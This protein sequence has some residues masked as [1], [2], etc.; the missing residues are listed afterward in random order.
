LIL[1][2]AFRNPFWR[3]QDTNTKALVVEWRDA[4]DKNPGRLWVIRS[5]AE[6]EVQAGDIGPEP[7]GLLIGALRLSPGMA[8]AHHSLAL[9]YEKRRDYSR[10]FSGYSSE[11]LYSPNAEAYNGAGIALKE[12]GRFSEG[13]AMYR[14]AIAANTLRPEYAYNLGQLEMLDGRPDDAYAFFNKAIA[15]DPVNVPRAYLEQ[16]MILGA[17]KMYPQAVEKLRA[18]MKLAPRDARARL[19]LAAAYNGAGMYEE[20]ERELSIALTASPDDADAL[21]LMARVRAAQGDHSPAQP[22]KSGVR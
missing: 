7:E 4:V 15:L 10:A 3:D 22:N 14:A 5:L 21:R 12:L 2:T 9:L 18:Y 1:L 11:I 16:G 13:R 6:F 19:Y 20:A 8:S 17:K